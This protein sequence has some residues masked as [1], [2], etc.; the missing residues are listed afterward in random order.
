MQGALRLYARFI[1]P[2]PKSRAKDEHH[3]CRP[4]VDNLLKSVLDGLNGIVY[5]DDSQIVR[6][7]AD[8]AY[9][10]V[11]GVPSVYVC[12]QRHAPLGFHPH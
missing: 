1:M 12:I 8:K 4:D 3:V 5:N 2:R 6:I 7:E 10:G 9:E 11:V